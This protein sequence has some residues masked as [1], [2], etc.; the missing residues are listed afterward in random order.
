MFE[1]KNIAFAVILVVIILV[2]RWLFK[3]LDDELSKP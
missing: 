1:E 2:T 3:S